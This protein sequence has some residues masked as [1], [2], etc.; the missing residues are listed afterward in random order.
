MLQGPGKIRTFTAVVTKIL[1]LVAREGQ[2]VRVD[3]TRDGAIQYWR[4]TQF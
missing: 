2:L 4:S 1:A 3:T